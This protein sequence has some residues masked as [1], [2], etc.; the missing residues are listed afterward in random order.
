VGK[1]I[2]FHLDNVS[3]D[4]RLAA[5]A[6]VPLWT[7][8]LFFVTDEQGST[9]QDLARSAERI[10]FAL[11]TMAELSLA[12]K[13]IEDDKVRLLFLGVSNQLFL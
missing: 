2:H 5:S 12:L 7:E 1:E 8:D 13:A 4:E 6:S 3:R 10:P 11:M 9:E